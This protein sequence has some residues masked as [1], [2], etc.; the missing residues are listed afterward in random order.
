MVYSQREATIHVGG[1]FH[2]VTNRRLSTDDL[3]RLEQAL[4]VKLTGIMSELIIGEFGNAGN[5][6]DFRVTEVVLWRDPE[7]EEVESER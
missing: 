1:D 7:D 5:A 6:L 2:A 3:H 4:Y